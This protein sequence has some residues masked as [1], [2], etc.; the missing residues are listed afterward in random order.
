MANLKRSETRFIDEVFGMGSGYVLRK[1][2]GLGS[3]R[4]DLDPLIADD[5][6][7]I[8]SGLATV[9]EGIG[10]LRTHGGDAHGRERG[11]KRLDPRIASLAIHAASTIALFLIETWQR[12]YPK[13]DLHRVLSDATA[14]GASA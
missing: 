11:Y 14:R 3:D 13:R 8:L 4:S 9:V 12:K 2:L 6:R 5:V 7:K 1:S 10:A